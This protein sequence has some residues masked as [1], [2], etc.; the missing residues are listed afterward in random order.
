[1]I[2]D[3]DLPFLRVSLWII[4]GIALSFAAIIVLAVI[5]VF[6]ALRSK[7]VSG[8]EGMKG[9]TGKALADFVSGKGKVFLHGEIWAAFTDD[10]IL[11]DDEV[12]V[13]RL[14]G[15]KVYIKKK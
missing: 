6:P 15:L 7:T 12:T 8:Q 11:K 1:M 13:E 2:F 3:T 5:Y 10:K 14:D 9:E 4:G